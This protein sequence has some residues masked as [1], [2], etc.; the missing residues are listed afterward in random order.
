MDL[1]A[2][3]DM[4]K[5][6]FVKFVSCRKW[7]ILTCQLDFPAN[8]SERRFRAWYQPPV[9]TQ[10]ISATATAARQGYSRPG[11][12]TWLADLAYVSYQI[13]S[14][15]YVILPVVEKRVQVFS[16]DIRSICLKL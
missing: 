8:S 1:A 6:L 16:S 15:Y 13:L 12:A 14:S 7:H 10:K 9:F 2:F 3:G 11:M 4:S 5:V